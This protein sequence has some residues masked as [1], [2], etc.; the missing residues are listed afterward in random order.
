MD[1]LLHFN[2]VNVFQNLTFTLTKNLSM[3]FVDADANIHQF[4]VKREDE[5]KEEEV[6]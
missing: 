4:C 2:I 6:K 5:R 1:K 3:H